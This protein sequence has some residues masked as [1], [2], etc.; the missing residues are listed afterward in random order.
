M[1]IVEARLWVPEDVLYYV[2]LPLHMFEI[3]KL[4]T[5]ESKK[6]EYQGCKPGG[7][8]WVK[9]GRVPGFEIE[10][11]GYASGSLLSLKQAFMKNV[12]KEMICLS[13]LILFL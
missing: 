11:K 4:R 5:I 8:V 3:F 7:W 13:Q 12:L 2:F 1:I 6:E 10:E 9:L